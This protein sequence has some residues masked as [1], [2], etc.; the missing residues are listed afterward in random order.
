MTIR[1]LAV[2]VSRV[3]RL[4]RGCV[5]GDVEAV[6]RVRPS[7]TYVE[8]SRLVSR[9]CRG[10]VEAVCRGCV[11]R[12]CQLGCICSAFVAFLL[13]F[14]WHMCVLP[15]ASLRMDLAVDWRRFWK[16]TTQAAQSCT[17]PALE[18][19]DSAAQNVRKAAIVP[20]C[21]KSSSRISWLSQ[22]EHLGISSP[23]Q[24][25]SVVARR[26]FLDII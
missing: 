3:S 8:V 11:S 9:V 4:C 21:V 24:G 26:R 13:H 14:F 22:A 10:C 5:E 18:A 16:A 17:G 12:L 7:L 20:L 6:S 23:H 19:I 2:E 1:A 15:L 25:L